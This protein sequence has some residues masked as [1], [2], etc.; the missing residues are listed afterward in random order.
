MRLGVKNHT[1]DD[2]DGGPPGR[3]WPRA[4]R[5]HEPGSGR[6]DGGRGVVLSLTLLGQL[7]QQQPCNVL[8]RRAAQL[9]GLLATR[10]PCEPASHLTGRHTSRRRAVRHERLKT[11]AKS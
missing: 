10:R 9:G 2:P 6:W 7:N 8:D 1:A 3:E 11:H 4:V 5:K